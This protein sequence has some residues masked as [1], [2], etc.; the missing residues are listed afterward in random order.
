[1]TSPL[2]HGPRDGN[3]ITGVVLC[4]G[5]G[6]RVGGADK[7]LLPWRGRPLIEHVIAR[8][9]PQVEGLLISA[10]RNIG[11]YARYGRVITDAL[12]D[13]PG[14]LAG[15]HAALGICPT[16]WLLACPGDAPDLPMDLAERLLAA[17]KAGIEG[18][19]PAT[20]AVAH[21]GERIQPL[22][23]LLHTSTR[24]SLGTYL[25][26]G[27]RSVHGWLAE[28]APAVADFSGAAAAFRSRNSPD[29][30]EEPDHSPIC[31]CR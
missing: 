8:L 19:E 20:A 18:A 17:A 14:P 23:V 7:P 1:M 21:D 4:G 13:F 2:V 31:D 16:P 12:P 25:A 26:R 5:A 29:D 15:I 6:R 30:F 24:T 10:N 11:R 3:A 22:P 28:I 9:D 27:C